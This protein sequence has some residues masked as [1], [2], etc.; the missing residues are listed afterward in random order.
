MSPDVLIEWAET[1]E[2]TAK[3]FCNDPDCK[4]IKLKYNQESGFAFEVSDKEA[5]DCIIKAIQEYDN[6]QSIIIREQSRILIEELEKI[7]KDL[8]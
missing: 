5:V 1:I 6:S 8:K 7:K 4:R 3:E 2:Q